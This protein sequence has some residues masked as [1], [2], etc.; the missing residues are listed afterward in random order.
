[1]QYITTVYDSLNY[2][3]FF[4]A[5]ALEWELSRYGPVC[6]LNIHHQNITMQTLEACT[7]KLLKGQLAA[8][9]LEAVKCRHFIRAQ[10]AFPVVDRN[11]AAFSETDR[12]YFGSDEIWNIHR[13]KIRKS[14]E[15]F[16]WHY[17]ESGRI[18]L[19]PSI[20]RTQLTQ[21]QSCGYIAEE[22]NRF[23]A[24][25][26][27]D[28]HTKEVIDSITGRD[29]VLV[30]DPTLLFTKEDYEPCREEITEEPFI[31]FYA[32]GMMLNPEVKRQIKAFAAARGLKLISV[33]RWFDFCDKCVPASPGQFLDYVRKAEYVITETFHGLMFS[34]IYEKQFFVFP[35]GNVKVE[36]LMDILD[37]KQRLCTADAPM[38]EI[39]RS[40]LDYAEVTPRVRAHGER[41][42]SFIRAQA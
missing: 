34:L 32:Y 12:F 10:R 27:R 7:K 35:C 5:K 14:K 23:A 36:E 24:I 30:G 29:T 28:V 41:L 19:A 11:R 2:G 9:K 13:E 18:A 4:Q 17:P 3:S 25:S 26:V 15:F 21:M 20:N 37:V 33:G 40:D 16:G 42:R 1:M 31:L 38:E 8:A 39:V 6:F 22:L